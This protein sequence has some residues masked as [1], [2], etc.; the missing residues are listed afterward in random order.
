MP[1][2]TPQDKAKTFDK[3]THQALYI[4]EINGVTSAWYKQRTCIRLGC[5]LSLYPLVMLMPVVF[6]GLHEN[7]KLQRKRYWVQGASLDEV[8]YEDDAICV[9]AAAINRLLKNKESERHNYV[10]KLNG[11]RCEVVYFGSASNIKYAV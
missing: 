5:P 2:P 10:L 8:L 3:V 11:S 9:N 6:Y 7:G 1:R 4:V